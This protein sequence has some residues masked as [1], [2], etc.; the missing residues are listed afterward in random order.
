MIEVSV[1]FEFASD[2]VFDVSK[3]VLGGAEVLC[4]AVQ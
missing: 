3:E 1:Y 2:Y 4:E